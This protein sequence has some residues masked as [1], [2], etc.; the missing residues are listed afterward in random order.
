M[1]VTRTDTQKFITVFDLNT[2]KKDGI[3]LSILDGDDIV[4]LFPNQYGDDG[5]RCSTCIYHQNDVIS[6][7]PDAIIEF[8]RF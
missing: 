1:K 2:G 8:P 7:G 5:T 6:I 4:V 3:L